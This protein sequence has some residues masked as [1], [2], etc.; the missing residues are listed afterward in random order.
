M[1]GEASL[2]G[3]DVFQRALDALRRA[4][5][6]RKTLYV[7]AGDLAHVGP[8]FGDALPWSPLER[9][10]LRQADEALIDAM[11]SGDSAGFFDRIRSV[12]DR[13]RICGGPPIYL[14]LRMLEGAAGAPAGYEQCSADPQDA[15]FVSIAGAVLGVGQS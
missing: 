6:G 2:E 12:G 7:A 3:H 14:T 11:T 1:L 8:A 5:E 9:A 10:T 4:C 15:S 13:N